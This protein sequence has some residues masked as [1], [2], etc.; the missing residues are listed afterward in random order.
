[1]ISLCSWKQETVQNKTVTHC[2]GVKGHC[3]LHRQLCDDQDRF[4]RIENFRADLRIN[5]EYIANHGNSSDIYT[6]TRKVLKIKSQYHHLH[7]LV[8]SQRYYDFQWFIQWFMVI[9]LIHNDLWER[10]AQIHNG[11]TV[12]HNDVQWFM[13]ICEIC[14]DLHLFTMDSMLFMTIGDLGDSNWFTVDA[15]W[16]M[17]ICNW[18]AVIWF[19]MKH[20]LPGYVMEYWITL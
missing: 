2:N 8:R 6:P 12:I 10:F 19:T 18:F 9:T 3:C 7:H 14:I 20:M 4:L 11:F 15:W 1:M 5:C 17:M 13:K 16:C